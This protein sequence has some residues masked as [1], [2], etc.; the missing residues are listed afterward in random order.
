MTLRSPESTGFEPDAYQDAKGR[1]DVD[2]AQI[3]RYRAAAA[4]RP[5]QDW[6]L[7][8]AER[9]ATPPGLEGARAKLGPVEK[10]EIKGYDSLHY[11]REY[12]GDNP[13]LA[14]QQELVVEDLDSDAA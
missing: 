9:K 12:S 1:T 3:A 5:D 4:G 10:L 7:T 6:R 2:D 11:Y 14:G 8:D 13:T